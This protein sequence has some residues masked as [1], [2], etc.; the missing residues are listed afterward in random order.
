VLEVGALNVNGSLRESAKAVATYWG[1]DLVPGLDVDQ[2]LED[3]HVLPFPDCSY[4]IVMSSS[5]L[6]H[7]PMFW[8]TFAEMCRVARK[9]IYVSAPVQGPAHFHPVDCW[10]FYPDAGL[11]LAE[12]ARHCG[13]EIKLWDSF[14]YPPAGV[15]FWR[16]FVGVWT[17]NGSAPGQRLSEHFSSVAQDVRGE[18][19]DAP[20]NE[21]RPSEPDNQIPLTEN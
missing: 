11:A 10:R 4:D 16:D 18:I 17:K 13:H 5:T 1:V 12:W 9:F 20:P 6:E 15:E 7:D 8:R 3:A 2:A 14:A 21:Q 19:S